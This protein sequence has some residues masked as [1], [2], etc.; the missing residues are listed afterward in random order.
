MEILICFG[1]FLLVAVGTVGVFLPI[2]PSPLCA[3]FGYLLYFLCWENGP[4][5][6]S[7][8]L[9]ATALTLFAHLFEFVGSYFG[10]KWFGAT[11]RGGLG[12][13]L[14]GII[15]PLLCFLLPIPG[16]VLLGLII[17]PIVGAM[18]GELLGNREWGDA[19]K[20]GF[21]TIVGGL[22]A[23][24]LK[25]LVCLL[26]LV[27]LIAATGWHLGKPWAEKYWGTPPAAQEHSPAPAAQIMLSAQFPLSR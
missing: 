5:G 22:A 9:F 26:L 12:A 1:A 4:I 6:W 14:G 13:L 10:A 8:F 3:W 25:L 21:G 20:A 27:T 2:I 7:L 11:W 17:G 16:G 19:A 23:V 24:L 15:G 18:T